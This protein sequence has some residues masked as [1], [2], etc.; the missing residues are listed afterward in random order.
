MES[1]AWCKR[2]ELTNRRLPHRVKKTRP[3]TG[4]VRA[5]S[6][7]EVP[8]RLELTSHAEYPVRAVGLHGAQVTVLTL[9][10]SG[11]RLIPDVGRVADVA[12]CHVERRIVVEF[13]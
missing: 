11:R 2:F 3:K 10:R 4:R 5:N 7:S 6:K 9:L 12:T 13:P 8:V 1:T